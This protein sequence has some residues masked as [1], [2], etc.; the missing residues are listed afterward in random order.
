MRYLDAADI[1]SRITDSFPDKE[2]KQLLEDEEKLLDE[3]SREF[4]FEG[5]RRM[6]LIRFNRFFGKESDQNRYHWEGRMG[7]QDM[8]PAVNSPFFVAGTPDYMNWFPIPSEDKRSNPNFKT[9]VEGDPNNTFASE[10]G[11]GYTY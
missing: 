6:D 2:L 10:G 7:K 1:R 9:D 4:W 8:P 11:D 3:W 5:R